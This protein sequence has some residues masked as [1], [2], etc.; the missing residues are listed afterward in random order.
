PG[1]RQQRVRRE[2]EADSPAARAEDGEHP[3]P[4]APGLVLPTATRGGRLEPQTAEQ[5]QPELQ[6]ELDDQRD[7]FFHGRTSRAAA[8]HARPG[9]IASATAAAIRLTNS[10]SASE[11]ATTSS[12]PT[13][14]TTWYRSSRR[15]RCRLAS[16]A[17]QTPS[18]R[19]IT[20]TARPSACAN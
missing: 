18:A 8:G 4:R 13:P 9:N 1:V 5:L 6:E 20:P 7:E 12:P 11:N 15:Y 10:S 17:T 3:E 19:S 2:H 14:H 16:C